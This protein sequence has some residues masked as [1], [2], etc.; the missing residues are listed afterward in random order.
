MHSTFPP[1]YVENCFFFFSNILHTL[2]LSNLLGM[3]SCPS[4]FFCHQHQVLLVCVCVCVCYKY[5]F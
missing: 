2:P 1:F 4:S 3:S 5:F